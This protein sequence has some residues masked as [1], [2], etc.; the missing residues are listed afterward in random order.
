MIDV[1]QVRRL[2]QL[3]KA[4]EISELQVDATRLRIACKPAAD[5]SR[6]SQ[7]W[8]SLLHATPAGLAHGVTLKTIADWYESGTLVTVR[9]PVVGIIERQGLHAPSET[10][11]PGDTLCRI[12]V[13]NLGIEVRATLPGVVAAAYVA[14]GDPVD[15][16]SLLFAI[17][18]S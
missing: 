12:R 5:T 18:A 2:V 17:R 13:L 3:M 1:D 16:G 11:V 8:S 4:G 7:D 14:A 6:Q 10:V 15:Y 9:S